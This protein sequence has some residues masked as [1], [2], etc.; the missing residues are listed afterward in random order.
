MF[1]FHLDATA[2]M[3]DEQ[4]G[5]YGRIGGAQAEPDFEI[6]IGSMKLP[7]VLNHDLPPGLV[8]MS[9]G[10][11]MALAYRGRVDIFN[12]QFLE[13]WLQ[14]QTV[15]KVSLQCGHE[16]AGMSTL[17][18]I[19]AVKESEGKSK[20]YMLMR[21]AQ[22][23]YPEGNPERL[24]FEWMHQWE[25]QIRKGV[26]SLGLELPPEGAKLLERIKGIVMPVLVDKWQATNAAA[27][28]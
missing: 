12:R 21:M 3:F 14:T 23:T 28:E 6:K 1:T 17:G 25:G 15:K 10:D 4:A 22:V 26:E 13:D 2:R 5:G 11:E 9:S 27:T 20:A 8:V 7:V 18:I 19:E 24:F 16:G